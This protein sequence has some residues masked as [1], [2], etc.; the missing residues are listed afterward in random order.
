M[1][2][3]ESYSSTSV[4]YVMSSLLGSKQCEEVQLYVYMR[5]C[6]RVC[7]YEINP[8]AHPLKKRMRVRHML[9]VRYDSRSLTLLVALPLRNLIGAHVCQL[10]EGRVMFISH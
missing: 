8:C 9:Y 10:E 4:I 6:K 1:Y 3:T 5:D 2:N 7:E